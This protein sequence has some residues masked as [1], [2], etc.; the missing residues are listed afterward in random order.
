MI[1]FYYKFLQFL[2]CSIS[3]RSLLRVVVH[4]ADQ[5]QLHTNSVSGVRVPSG[6]R[7]Q[8]RL[9]AGEHGGG[10][11]ASQDSC[12]W[13]AFRFFFLKMEKQEVFC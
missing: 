4:R 9:H 11:R 2:Q 5:R 13:L 7:R 12:E 3:A 10:G 6:P 1:F 8:T